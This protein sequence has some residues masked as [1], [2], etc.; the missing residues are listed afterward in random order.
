MITKTG[1][2]TIDVIRDESKA[3]IVK[4][5]VTCAVTDARPV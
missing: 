4:G 3:R 2:S 1:C 5:F